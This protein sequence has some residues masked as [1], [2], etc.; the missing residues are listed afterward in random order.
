M[1]TLQQLRR[2]LE[3]LAEAPAVRIRD[4]RE[5][6]D[7][8]L[9]G[10]DVELD[11]ATGPAAAL[12][13]WLRRVGLAS[14]FTGSRLLKPAASAASFTTDGF[15]LSLAGLPLALA[16]AAGSKL[17]NSSPKPSGARSL[18][19]IMRPLSRLQPP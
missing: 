7:R 10:L 15:G 5:G 16:Q 1:L 18:A 11:V 12:L 4:C 14:A 8:L 9:L 2:P 3:R 13:L 19:V 17:S 6:V